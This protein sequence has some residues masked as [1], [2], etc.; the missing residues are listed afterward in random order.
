MVNGRRR[1]CA[2][3]TPQA[4]WRR[5]SVPPP[6]VL[7]SAL[8]GTDDG[9]LDARCFAC[10]SRHGSDVACNPPYDPD[11]T[12]FNPLR[13]VLT[14]GIHFERLV[15]LPIKLFI[16]ANMFMAVDESSAPAKS[17]RRGFFFWSLLACLPT[18]F[19]AV[20]IDGEPYWDGGFAGNCYYHAGSERATR[21]I[22]SLS[23]S[24]R[25]E[26]RNT[27]SLRREHNL[28]A[29]LAQ[30]RS[31]RAAETTSPRAKAARPPECAD[32]ICPDCPVAIMKRDLSGSA[33]S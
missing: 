29:G 15:T 5:V 18:M 16:T 17:R 6:S 19:R 9:P 33:K 28:G 11:P 7:A 13:Q 4:Y 3:R 27:G 14:E 32:R 31:D 8:P 30:S 10:L 23:R 1:W 21:M 22:P 2:D 24:I 12:G 20:E 26:R 25:R